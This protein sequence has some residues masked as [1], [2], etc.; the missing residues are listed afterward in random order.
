MPHGAHGQRRRGDGAVGVGGHSRPPDEAPRDWGFGAEGVMR[1]D[2][3]G[4][5]AGAALAGFE[6]APASAAETG[7]IAQPFRSSARNRIAQPLPG[8]G[9]A[10]SAALMP[11]Y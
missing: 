1:R 7:Q 8:P 9:W 6:G 5:R 10:H 3:A 11:D 2:G 4:R